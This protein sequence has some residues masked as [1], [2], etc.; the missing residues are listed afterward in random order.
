MNI[1]LWIPA[2][3][4]LIPAE[5]CGITGFRRND[6]GHQKVLTVYQRVEMFEEN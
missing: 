5:S 3:S 1:F 6:M 2:D 4:G